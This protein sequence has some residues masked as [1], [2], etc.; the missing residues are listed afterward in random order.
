MKT[1]RVM[2]A[3]HCLV[4]ALVTFVV[5]AASAQVIV[6]PA[7]GNNQKDDGKVMPLVNADDLLADYL[8]GARGMIKD[9]EYGRAIEILQKMIARTDAGGLIGTKDSRRFVSLRGK[10]HEVIGSMPPEGLKLYRFLYDAQAER[11]YKEA[12]A[13]SDL[14]KMRAVPDRYL[15]TTIGPRALDMLGNIYFDRGEF[16]QAAGAWMK[17]LRL[18]PGQNDPHVLAK[19]AIAEHLG[20][21]HKQARKHLDL[22]KKKYP[23]AE[24]VFAGRK[25]PLVSFVQEI[26][27]ED[28]D[29]SAASSDRDVEGWPGV[30]GTRG[31]IG[32]MSDCEVVLVPRWT[33]PEGLRSR[34]L[35]DNLIA[36]REELSK[37]RVQRQKVELEG[38]RPMMD[39]VV[40]NRRQKM[41]VP[42]LI[43]PVVVGETILVR[44]EENVVALD[45]ITGEMVWRTYK[46][47]VTRQPSRNTSSRHS[48]YVPYYYYKMG[49]SG[50]YALTVGGDTVFALAGLPPRQTR[51]SHNR[52]NTGEA[53]TSQ[54]VAVSIRRQGTILWKVGNGE[55]SDELLQVCRFLSAPVFDAGRLYTVVMHAENYFLVCL[56]AASGELLWKTSVAQAPM[57]SS[58]YGHM[59]GKE[60]LTVG[61]TPAVVDG[62]VFVTTNAGVVAA[63][64]AEAGQP[65]WAYQYDTQIGGNQRYYPQRYNSTSPLHFPPNPVIVSRGRVIVLPADS[66]KILAF[67]ADEG[68]MLWSA[69]RE[70]MSHLTAVGEDRLVLSSPEA[71]VLS[72]K[73]G[74]LVGNSGYRGRIKDVYGRPAVS[75]SSILLSSAGKI[76]RLDREN[77]NVATWNIAHPDSLLG[78]LVAVDGKLIAAN[79]A[80]ICGYFSY[81][82]ARESLIQRQEKARDS[83]KVQL[84]FQRAQLAFNAQRFEQAL[85]D[86]DETKKL[87]SET[88]TKEILHQLP[89][90]YFRTHVGLANTADSSEEMRK[91]F[92]KAREYA[93]TKTEKAHMMLRLAKYYEKVGQLGKAVELAQQISEDYGQVEMVDLEIGP[94]ANMTVRFGEDEN[95]VT[96][97]V[98]G[99]GFVRRMLEIHGR[100]LY[101]KYDNIAGEAYRK[102]LAENDPEA[103]AAVS[104]RWPNSEW[105]DDALLKAA[106]IYYVRAADLEDEEKASQLIE[107]AMNHLIEVVAMKD[108][109]LRATAGVA[110]AAIYVQTGQKVAASL[111]LDSLGEVPA[112]K[113]IAFADIRGQY[114]DIIKQLEKG[115]LPDLPSPGEQMGRVETPLRK[116][117]TIKGEKVF[118]LTDQDYRPVRLAQNIFVLKD[119]RIYMLDTTA[120]TFEDGIVWAGVTKK[121]DINDVARY[122]SAAPGMRLL[123]SLSEDKSVFVVVTRKSVSAFSVQSGKLRWEKSAST[124][125]QSNPRFMGVGSGHVL[126][127]DT[128]GNLSC[129]K[130]TDGSLAWK[131]KVPGKARYISSPPMF[132]EGRVFIRYNGY[133]E[134]ACYDLETGKLQQRWSA[135]QRLQQMVSPSNLLAV[136]DDGQLS[137]YEPGNYDKPLW[138]KK[139]GAKRYPVILAISKDR[140]AVSPGYNNDKVDVLSL[141][142]KGRVVASVSLPKQKGQQHMPQDAYFA[143]GDLF[144]AGSNN[145]NRGSKHY[146]GRLSYYRGATISRIDLSGKNKVLWTTEIEEP[147]NQNSYLLPMLAGQKHLA[148]L[149]RSTSANNLDANSAHLLDLGTGKVREKMDITGDN[150]NIN[151]VRHSLISAPLIMNGRLIIETI[152]GVNVYR[153][154]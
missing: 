50:Q 13:S 69:N 99:Q 105:V 96:G 146:Y 149:N 115:Q 49:D 87:A 131:A 106:E 95:R 1:Y 142:G 4:V 32:T 83:R 101:S 24:G 84:L 31:G 143:H 112:K 54:L 77:H 136:I 91:H 94:K 147:S 123:G 73:D 116:L 52:T 56:D 40:G 47:P 151:S 51:Y 60:L 120:K 154:Q 144:V 88:G 135:K 132:D 78:N 124:Y 133:K 63:F 20:Q 45:M 48:G 137:V 21:E 35:M 102:A 68:A 129:V 62:R 118:L 12:V 90:L 108:S 75:D 38:G 23:K 148:V 5:S 7:V 14:G 64:D 79:A 93:N 61:S 139:Y 126:F 98:L 19:I 103:L 72:M 33:L 97:A 111:T 100:E 85:A 121:L 114:K 3:R 8:D 109:P 104:S 29:I 57:V 150:A 58:R 15:H 25:R 71:R 127:T 80:G 145:N 22:L 2:S 153:G 122:S 55:G 128:Q 117:Y 119:N 86:L 130:M 46:L 17:Y 30:G 152:K 18:K 89:T 39:F 42:T 67:S 107:Q 125:G 140:V 6:R 113:E 134:M 66:E 141:S 9:K 74:K 138:T 36:F 65:V 10:A 53:Q 28:L 11:L 37:F 26:L 44:T 27:E 92:Q 16:P 82:E 70:D 59:R 110:E 41:S 81:D 43:D 34:K 76:Y